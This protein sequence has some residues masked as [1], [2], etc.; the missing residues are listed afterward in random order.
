MRRHRD[1]IHKTPSGQKVLASPLFDPLEPQ[2]IRKITV[3][4][5][6]STF[7]RTCIFFPLSLLF[8]SFLFF[9]RLFSSFLFFSLLFSSFL[10]FSLLF[11]SFLF[12][13][14]LWSSFCFCLSSFFFLLSSLLL[15]SLF[16]LLSSLLFSDSSHLS[17]LSEVWLLNFLRQWLIPYTPCLDTS[18][19]SVDL[20]WHH[21]LTT[22]DTL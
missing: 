22:N 20:Q 9:S 2:I 11:S 5:N 21:S 13:S 17:I 18:A 16:S 6:F 10:F 12:F 4:R 3:N 7:P 1:I 8:S 15:S 14:L 19:Y